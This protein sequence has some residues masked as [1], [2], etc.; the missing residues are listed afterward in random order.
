[1]AEWTDSFERQCYEFFGLRPGQTDD[2]FKAEISSLADHD[3]QELRQAMSREDVINDRP[4]MATIES[5]PEGQGRVED[6][7]TFEE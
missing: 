7:T 5:K 4:A 3:Q 6:K 1:M 2:E